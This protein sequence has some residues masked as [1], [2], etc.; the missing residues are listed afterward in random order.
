MKE[1]TPSATV[2]INSLAKQRQQKGERVYN[3]AAGDPVLQAHKTIVESAVAQASKRVVPYPPLEGLP[4][5]RRL[6]SEWMNTTY[7][8]HYTPANVLVTCG[9]KFAIFGLIYSLVE[10]GEEVLI[11]APYWVSYPAIVEMAGAV[12]KI[13]PSTV[14][15]GWKISGDDVR[16]YATPKTKV[17]LFNNASNPTGVLYTKEEVQSILQAAKELNLMVI[18]DEV[19][20]GLVY[21]PEEFVSCGSFLQYDEIVVV[22]QSC[23]KNFGMTGWRVGFALGPESVVKA[24]ALLQGQTTTGT[25]LPSQW[26]AVGAFENASEVNGYVK[27]AMKRRRD[28]FVHTYNALFP[29]SIELPSSALYVFPTIR[30]TGVT[31]V[32]DSVRFCEELMRSEGIALVPGIAFGV[33][34]YV[35]FAF[36]EEEKQIEEALHALKRAVERLSGGFL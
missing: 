2:T 31:S 30:S 25:A 21:G 13:I 19:Y 11:P 16:R 26:A 7:H 9:G 34:G 4:E 28:L 33:E 32:E 29:E 6:V 35:R 15:Q 12:P 36:S 24:L 10:R 8:C 3:F 27:E 17:L 14:E 23:S 20:S 5:L 18:S 1:I 22:V